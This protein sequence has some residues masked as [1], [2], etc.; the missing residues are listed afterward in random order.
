M[1]NLRYLIPIALAA[2][3]MAVLAACGSDSSSDKLSANDIA[4]IGKTHITKAQFDAL[5]ERAKVSYK[6]QKQT[7]PKEGTSGFQTVKAEA[8]SF[9]VQQAERL[10]K[11]D[12]M[13]IK[14]SD[15]DV[16]KRLAQIKKQYFKNDEKKYEAYL[17]QNKLT[18]ADVLDSVREQLVSEA[19]S[20]KLTKN[21]KVS[22]KQVS[23]YYKTNIS[24]YTQQPTRVVRYILVKQKAT[25]QQIY[26]QLKN[27][28]DATWCKL[29]KK[30]A[31]D[32]SGQQCGRASFSKGQTVPVFDKV[33]FGTPAHVVHAP[34]Y[35]PTS[36]KSWFVVEPLGPIAKA[37]VT[38]QSKV[39]SQIKQ[40]LLQADKNTAMSDWLAGLK[41]SFCSGSKIKYAVGYV[42]SPDPCAATTTSSTTG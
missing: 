26:K 9:L 12:S 10:Q 37:A 17:K 19:V 20:A 11:A 36:Y 23:D 38:P 16:D 35:D 5:I 8:V 18:E 28:N 1:S 22:D 4:V 39:A 24:Q 33:A 7:F 6:Q 31:K 27:G 13:G 41:K 42:A 40:T 15:A 3:L 21:L 14:I 25:A 34:F 29:A 2:A 32:S 30:Y